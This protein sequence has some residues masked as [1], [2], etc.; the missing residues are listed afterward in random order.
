MVRSVAQLV[1]QS[2][3][4]VGQLPSDWPETAVSIGKFDALH[5]GHQKLLYELVEAAENH[6]LAATVITFDR[7]PAHQLDPD[8]VPLPVIG[9]TQKSELIAKSGVDALVTLTFDAQLAELTPERFVDEILAPLRAKLVMVGDD[10]RF[11]QHGSGDVSKLRE[12]GALKGF[13]VRAVSKVTSGGEAIST[14]RIRD[15]LNAGDVVG[16]AKL[17]GRNHSTTGVI[18]HGLKIGRTIGFPTANMSR[19]AE[20]Y[21]PLDGVYAGWLYADGQRYPAAHSVGINET[22]QAVPRL[23]ES[24]VLDR[25]DLDLYDKV[26][27]LEYVEFV[28][29]TAKFGSKEELIDE[30]NRDVAKVRTALGICW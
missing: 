1:M 23:V 6:S 4:S 3:N 25:D 12:L 26:V 30:I 15:L 10:F 9:K 28:R 5:L 22:F 13:S 21:L 19:E 14:S 17:L 8:R 18:E 24:Y 29:P 7:H 2:F 11:G 16:A 20:G 27:T